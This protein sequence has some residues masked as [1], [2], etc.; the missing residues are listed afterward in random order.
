MGKAFLVNI[1]V[2]AS[3]L[4]LSLSPPLFLHIAL[5]RQWP[6]TLN[7]KRG[8]WRILNSTKD[9]EKL[10]LVTSYREKY[11][12]I[13]AEIVTAFWLAGENGIDL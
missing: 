2:Y 1:P 11:I 6:V 12:K 9:K 3:F 5:W 4:N 10:I 8:I 7:P 13:Q